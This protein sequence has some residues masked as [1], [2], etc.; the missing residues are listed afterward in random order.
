MDVD[1]ISCATH[2]LES[3]RDISSTYDFRF[4]TFFH[5]G[6]PIVRRDSIKRQVRKIPHDPSVKN[7]SALKKQSL[8]SLLETLIFNPNLR[9]YSSIL[10]ELVNDGHEVGLHGGKNHGRWASEALEW[11]VMKIESEL[12][13][14]LSQLE[15]SVRSQVKGFSS[16]EWKSSVPVETAAQR[17]GFLYIADGHGQGP[18]HQRSSNGL[19]MINTNGCGEPGGVG[20]I[21]YLDANFESR[22]A[23]SRV[24]QQVLCQGL[25][26]VFYDHPGYAGVRGRDTF[27]WF[28]EQLKSADLEIC[29]LREVA[30][31]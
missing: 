6:R 9:K 21:E 18:A 31:V 16:P 25:P 28:V 26:T 20:F 30:G 3:L 7:L 13:W 14:A 15:P 12:S 17:Q 1:T 8:R 23:K 27:I 2:G 4:T 22:Q 29:T 5:L 24:L 19:S 11:D 10:T